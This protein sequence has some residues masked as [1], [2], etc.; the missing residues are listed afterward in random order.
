MKDLYSAFGGAD[1]DVWHYRTKSA[2]PYHMNN[3]P[4]GYRVKDPDSRLPRL[5]QNRS[6]EPELVDFAACPSVRQLSETAQTA[7]VNIDGLRAL[8]EYLS[9]A[10]HK[11]SCNCDAQA[12]SAK[13]IA[14]SDIEAIHAQVPSSL[15]CPPYSPTPRRHWSHLS[16]LRWP[17]HT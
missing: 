10:G 11:K 1:Q 9:M 5:G 7:A 12:L 17:N 14:S 6:G 16:L 13:S 8:L 4:A 2:V 3:G 15:R